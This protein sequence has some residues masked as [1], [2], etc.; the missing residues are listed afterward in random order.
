MRFHCLLDYSSRG[1]FGETIER[2][3]L[4][5]LLYFF[6]KFVGTAEFLCSVYQRSNP[7]DL[8]I[9]FGVAVKMNK[10]CSVGVFSV[11]RDS[12]TTDV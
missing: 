9:P 6:R 2:R 3:K 12:F 11:D 5:D 1:P 7:R 10:L 8:V 4:F